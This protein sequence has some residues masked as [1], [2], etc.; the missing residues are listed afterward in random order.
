MLKKLL[1]VS[2]VAI[3]TQVGNVSTATLQTPAPDWINDAVIYEVNFRQY[4]ESGSFDDFALELPRLQELG[5]DVLWF[6]PIHRIS[7]ERRLGTLGSYYSVSD[8]RSIN[9]EYGT[10]QDFRELVDAAHAAGFKVILDWIANHTGWDHAW[11]EEHPDWYVRDSNNNIIIPP[12]TNWSDVAELNFNNAELRSQMISEMAYWIGEFDVD[13]FR[14]DYSTGVPDSFWNSARTELNAIKPIYLLA[15]NYDDVELLDTAFDT[16]YNWPLKDIFNNIGATQTG[17]LNVIDLIKAQKNLYPQNT[18][19][20]NFITNH[21]ENSWSGTEYER[22][23]KA[24]PALSAVY[25]TLPGVPLI[26]TGQEIGLRKRLEFF[27]KDTIDWGN[28]THL[29]YLELLTELKERNTALDVGSSAGSFRALNNSNNR[30]ISFLRANGS[31]R[32]ITV[33]NISNSNQMVKLNLKEAKGTY[34]DLVTGRVS[35]LNE[36]PSIYLAPFCFQVLEKVDSAPVGLN[37]VAI[38]KPAKT[39]K[40]KQQIQLLPLTTPSALVAE[41]YQW[42]SLTPDVVSISTTGMVKALKKG[43]GRIQL[44][45]GGKSAVVQVVVR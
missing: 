1:V 10:H 18:F 34:R 30:V 43:L 29:Q 20:M 37:K 39:L 45:A 21:D 22:L 41:Q 3:L 23:G 17:A 19:P 13:G 16:N 9:P 38:Q 6:M 32:V 42:K 26:Y 36:M 44:K 31:D 35:L 14:L 40:L 25:F 2:L 33:A 4:T 27:E 15:E 7:A 24:V 28:K 5:V 8:Y 11:I 12:N